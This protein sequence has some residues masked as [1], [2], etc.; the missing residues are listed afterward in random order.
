MKMARN[1]VL[2][3][4]LPPLGINREQAAELIGVSPSTF[5]K[6]V[7]ARKMP[8]PRIASAGRL[9]YD[10]SELAAAFRQLPHQPD[11][12]DPIDGDSA[13]GNPWDDE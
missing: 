12:N 6:L 7:A 3:A 2:P 9:I 4:S 11:P 8:R 13:N 10:V 1:V 5:D